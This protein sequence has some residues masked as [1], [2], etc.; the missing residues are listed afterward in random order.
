M[1]GLGGSAECT[2][3]IPEEEFNAKALKRKD[4]RRILSMP[5]R[6]IPLPDEFFRSSVGLKISLE[7]RD[8]DGLQYTLF[9]RLR[10]EKEASQPASCQRLLLVATNMLVLVF[11]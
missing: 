11:G 3:V 6:L 1:A 8:S 2:G 10:S 9:P 4:A 7:M 5:V